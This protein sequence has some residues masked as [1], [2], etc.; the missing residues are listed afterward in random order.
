MVQRREALRRSRAAT[1]RSA[2]PQ[3]HAHSP[4]PTASARAYPPDHEPG[5]ALLATPGPRR[6]H[7]VAAEQG[8]QAAGWVE[9]PCTFS[10][11]NYRAAAA[12]NK[13]N[14]SNFFSAGK[15]DASNEFRAS[16]R[17]SSS[18]NP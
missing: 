9:P 3:S 7:T 12:S 14:S 6:A 16:S 18:V 1:L 5:P 15:N 11:G 8:Y 13:L 4:F 17:R 10:L 2:E